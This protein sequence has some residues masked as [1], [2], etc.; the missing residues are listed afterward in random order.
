M[1]TFDAY[2]VYYE[3]FY[4]DKGYADEVA[5]VDSFF[6][7]LPATEKSILELGCGSGGHA[8][9]FAN[10][11]Y[12]VSGIDQSRGM[13]QRANEKK[14]LLDSSLQSQLSFSESDLKS[15]DLQEKFSAVVSLFHV[16]NYQN[17][18][19]ELQSAFATARKHLNPGGLFLFD[20]WY[21]PAVLTERPE[22]R[23][24]RVENDTAV[25]TRYANPVMKPTQNIVDVNYTV[26]VEN[27]TDATFD[28]ITETHSM[29]YLFTPEIAMLAEK[30]NFKILK[31]CEWLTGKEPSFGTWSVCF[32]LEAL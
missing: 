14:S 4:Q 5:F 11:G 32:L 15:L 8:V 25:V 18:N 6:E 10:L 2:A 1:A 17:S 21:G 28:E 9:H 31:S 26:R 27:K 12:S 16:I 7:S 13:I 3:L 29:R 24:K 20:S 22:Q 23:E 30:N 19:E